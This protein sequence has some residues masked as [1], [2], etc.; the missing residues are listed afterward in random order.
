MQSSVQL[1]VQNA[2][3]LP[4]LAHSPPE[5]QSRGDVHGSPNAALPA[6][7]SAGCHAYPLVHVP[8]VGPAIVPLTHR[9]DAPHQPQPATGVHVPQ[10]VNREH[11]SV[12]PASVVVALHRAGSHVQPAPHAPAEGPVEVPVAHVLLPLHQ[13]H[14]ALGV[15]PAH[16]LNP[17]H[18]SV[19]TPA[20]GTGPPDG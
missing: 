15:Q 2:V 17:A 7:Q 13:P 14:I 3:P 1:R 4:V 19:G 6:V 20:S 11:G 8:D 9:P 5:A 18:G 10:P 16:E 12:E